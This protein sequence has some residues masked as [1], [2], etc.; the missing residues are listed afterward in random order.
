MESQ[1]PLQS[2]Q[3]ISEGAEGL[4]PLVN[5]DGR[6]CSLFERP[7]HWIQERPCR[8]SYR[9]PGT[10]SLEKISGWKEAGPSEDL[11]RI[12][13]FV[14][15]PDLCPAVIFLN[16]PSFPVQIL[17]TWPHDILRRWRDVYFMTC[18]L[19]MAVGA[20]WKLIVLFVFSLTHPSF[21]FVAGHQYLSN[22]ALK[23]N[24][25]NNPMMKCNSK[26]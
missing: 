22:Q 8:G 6:H 26:T 25:I 16:L 3:K 1:L 13:P 11:V 23:E 18:I 14:I 21:I 24:F 9:P 10:G 5:W 4:S 15:S 7:W 17:E 19:I 2:T 12:E 20:S